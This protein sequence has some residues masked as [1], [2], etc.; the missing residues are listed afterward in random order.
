[1]GY[2]ISIKE[3]NLLLESDATFIVNAS[4]TKL[5][6]GSGVSMAFKHHCGDILEKEM[7]ELLSRI[8]GGLSSGDVVA[9]SS[10]KATNFTYAL[11]VAV[12]NYNK[13]AK[14]K[15]PTLQII[16]VAMKQIEKY[17]Y[18]YFKNH[19]KG[20]IKLVLPLLGCGV[21]GLN[22]KDV[23]NIYKNF[24]SNRDIPF[25]C[26]VLIYAYG[27]RNYKIAQEVFTNTD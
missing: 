3:G 4:N 25:K 20:N 22:I 8:D 10:G 1:M 5:I 21:G 18:W 13:G 23:L 11:H 27:Q 19:E 24:F 15:K 7:Q 16:Y 2:N 14:I 26:E 9:T 6:L 17:L 12:M